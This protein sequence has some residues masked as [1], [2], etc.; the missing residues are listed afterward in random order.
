MEIISNVALISINETMLIQ[1]ISFLIFLFVFNRV[2]VRPLHGSV[3]ERK[4][5]VKKLSEETS[6]FEAQLDQISAQI[7]AQEAS[8]VKEAQ[9]MRHK[10]ETDGSTQAGHI[11]DEARHKVAL[12]RKDTEAAIKIA[13]EKARDDLAHEAESVAIGIMEKALNR[14]LAS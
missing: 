8:A 1:L 5:F 6:V 14:R 10:I 12:M 9:I 3:E 7:A 4:S 2:M 13:A 11:L